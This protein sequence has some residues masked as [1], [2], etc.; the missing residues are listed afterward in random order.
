MRLFVKI[1]IEFIRRVYNAIPSRNWALIIIIIIT[2]FIQRLTHRRLVY[3]GIT[4]VWEV[5]EWR[6]SAANRKVQPAGSLQPTP[7]L[8]CGKYRIHSNLM[9]SLMKK[10]ISACSASGSSRLHRSLY[11]SPAATALTWHTCGWRTEDTAIGIWKHNFRYFVFFAQ[12]H[13]FTFSFQSS[14]MSLNFV[15]ISR[16][17]VPSH[18]TLG[19]SVANYIQLRNDNACL[20]PRR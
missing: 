17:V 4:Q 7:P 15:L 14:T 18:A 9:F 12:T 11:M 3:N 16:Q 10:S 8:W 20:R 13:T 6:Q 1:Q 5:L 19:F 2:V